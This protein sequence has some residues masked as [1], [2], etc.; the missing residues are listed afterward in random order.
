VIFTL[1]LSVGVATSVFSVFDAVLL[2]PLPF[3][4]PE[5]I[6]RVQGYSPSGYQQPESWP[7]YLDER[8]QVRSFNALAAFLFWKDLA[9]ETPNGPTAIASV[10]TSDNF[11][12]VFGV[13]P[14]LGRT[15]L[16]GEQAEGK[17]NLAVL[18]AGAWKKYF[19]SASSVVG[20][21]V[22]LDGHA[23]Q[24]IGV[25]PDD[26][27]F[28][29]S[30][31]NAIYVPLRI[32]DTGDLSARGS[33]SFSLAGR[34]RDGVTMQQAQAEISQIYSNLG[35]A[36]PDTDGGRKAKIDMLS[37]AET[38]EPQKPLHL[39]LGAVFALLAVGGINL[40]GLFLMRGLQRE[41]EMALRVAIGAQRGRL[42]RQM[43]TE[44]LLYAGVGGAAGILVSMSL[45]RVMQSFIE[46]A[47]RRG[48]DIDLNYSVL[49]FCFLIACGV[50]LLAS[51]YPALRAAMANPNS[52]L[53]AGCRSG[54]RREE[55]RL[56]SMFV[57]VQVALTMVLVVVAGMLMRQVISYRNADI[58][59]DPARIGAADIQVPLAR[60]DGRGIVT[61]FYRPL[62]ERVS[63]I[64]GIQAVGVIN[65]IPIEM[66]G[67]NEDIHIAGQ[68]P[69][70]KNVEKLAE[71][72]F[73]STG[74]FDVFGLNLHGG[75]KLDPSLDKASN[76]TSIAV[77]NDAFVQ[78]FLPNGYGASIPRIDDSD[79]DETK[80]QLIG[81]MS[82]L[83][84]TFD[85]PKPKAEFDYLI[86]ELDDPQRNPNLSNMGLVWRTSGDPMQALAAIRN[87]VREVDATVPLTD[88][89]TMTDVV[90]EAIVMQRMMSWL[91]GIFAVLAL[92]LALA[93]IYGLVGFEVERS[94]RDIGVR[95]AL[96]ASR[97]AILG[98]VLKRIAWMLGSGIAAGLL[99]TFVAQKI[100]GMVIYFDAPKEAGNLLLL[101]LLLMTAGLAAAFLPA[102]RAASIEP[103]QALRAE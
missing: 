38:R 91:F 80:T 89:R 98:G 34:L 99:L 78:E 65:M 11:F 32:T 79:K 23:C 94:T 58:G 68:P 48:T 22:R 42:V 53:R 54:T 77:A 31:R 37:V 103:M 95:M 6:M 97:L 17:N 93:G 64:P 55:N 87:A 16:P 35:N 1:A 60:Y 73:V 86:D 4:R 18:S 90:S 30:A 8:A 19:N 85:A 84:Q 74:Y 69:T 13:H 83:R 51:L 50:S 88:A 7:A 71:M 70:P 66:W 82:N 100:I 9:A 57:M 39:L 46:H 20:S 61:A 62:L 92:T 72:R 15:F 21:T 59:F 40:A 27:R 28:P 41:H 81:V 3:Q 75:R 52:A 102:R 96:G 2:R 26:F 33:H 10:R 76:V 45:L 101:A 63:H 44:G 24:I 36:W 49:A 47:F 56:R 67:M 43:M 12:D 14:L 29:L 5:R 25:M